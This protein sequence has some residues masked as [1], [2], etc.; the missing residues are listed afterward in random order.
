MYRCDVC[1]RCSEPGATCIKHPVMRT[2][3]NR[4]KEVVRT[5]I[6]YEVKLCGYC[7]REITDGKA[8]LDQLVADFRR[9]KAKDAVAPE[10]RLG[11]PR[12]KVVRDIVLPRSA[13]GSNGHGHAA[14][15]NGT[16]AGKPK[17]KK[18]RKEERE[19]ER[20][21]SMEGKIIKR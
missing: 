19:R 11:P 15:G 1:D 18:Q 4:D 3:T 7:Q 14:N 20:L 12:K 10:Y 5:E 6:A 2:L 16:K 8:T 21:A 13:T 9:K 17:T